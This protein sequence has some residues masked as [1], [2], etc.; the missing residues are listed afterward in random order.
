MK[1]KWHLSSQLQ[2][3][4]SQLTAA[5][6]IQQTLSEAGF[7]CYFA[8]GCVRDALLGLTIDDIDLACS[9][10]TEQ[11]QALF[12]KVLTLGARFGSVTV[13]DE[14]GIGT[15]VTTFRQDGPYQDGRRPLSVAAAAPQI[16]AQRR[17]FT[18]NGL[19]YDPQQEELIDYVGGMDDLER[20]IIRAIG[21]PTKRF[22][23]D[24][25]RMVRA[26]R[27]SARF[28]FPIEQTTKEAILKTSA[29]LYP[30]TSIERIE[31]ELKKMAP[32]P[33]ATRRLFLKLL[34]DLGLFASLLP[35]IESAEVGIDAPQ[36]ALLGPQS[37]GNL[38]AR[39]RSATG[40]ESRKWLPEEDLLQEIED[41]TLLEQLFLL[42]LTQDHAQKKDKIAL[43]SSQSSEEKSA[44]FT[45]FWK[46]SKKQKELFELLKSFCHAAL[47]DPQIEQLALWTPLLLF[48]HQTPSW[49]KKL[50]SCSQL[51]KR[52]FGANGS[53]L[54]IFEKR[55]LLC[56]DVLEES[57]RGIK[58]IS[59]Q[60]LIEAGCPQGPLLSKMLDHILFL[61][62][63]Q[64]KITRQEALKSALDQ[65]HQWQKLPSTQA[66]T[67]SLKKGTPR[68]Q[69]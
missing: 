39:A 16:D 54:E 59:A 18:I 20:G 36:K 65:L 61:R 22:E 11:V 25:L 42:Y 27:F 26:A 67:K 5:L 60:E 64:P 30:K 52:I 62:L 23:E 68:N 46:V 50:H 41:L 45:S 24:R 9:A 66:K 49:K 40:G 7:L 14:E 13:I 12:P 17:D 69:V 21:D 32:F 35:N 63:E 37:E 28:S 47:E 1:K 55:L 56:S 48:A 29:D 57:A 44:L 58:L 3:A 33:A 31:A 53:T 19:F 4:P 43:F 15:E 51:L 6:N 34:F 38:R 10:S 8:G 2:V